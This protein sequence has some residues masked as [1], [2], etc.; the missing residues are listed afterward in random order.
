MFFKKNFIIVVICVVFF[1]VVFSVM[2]IDLIDI[3]LIIIGEYI[4][5]VCILVV[6]GGGIVDY[7]KYY[8]SVLNSIGKSNKLV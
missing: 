8:N 1:V 2:V 3:E 4:F 6:M 7:G 5:G